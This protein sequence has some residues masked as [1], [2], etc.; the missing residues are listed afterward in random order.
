MKLKAEDE[1]S[2]G[3]LA[4][5]LPY[6]G[7]KRSG[8]DR[9][10]ARKLGGAIEGLVGGL[11]LESR[12]REYEVGEDQAPKIAGTAAGGKEGEL[13]ERVLGLVKSLF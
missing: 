9:A 12:L 11:G 10:D 7:Q 6:I 3:Q 5:A 13:Y 1:A 2:A 4:R 8:D